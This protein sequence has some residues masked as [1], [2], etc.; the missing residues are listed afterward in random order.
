M[1]I[2][3]NGI[4]FEEDEPILKA[5]SRAFR[6]G[7]GFFESMRARNGKIL[8]QKDHEKRIAKGLSLMIMTLQEGKTPE[9]ILQDALQLMALNKLT[10]A[11]VRIQFFRD[12]GGTYLPEKSTAAY[13]IETNSLPH[14]NYVFN[15]LGLKLDIF[16]EVPK[17][18]NRLTCLKSG[19]AIAS[20]MGSIF[21]REQKLDDVLLLNEKGN[22]C[23]STN[24][25]VF[26]VFENSIKTPSLTEGA[27][28]GIMRIQTIKAA[29]E[30][31]LELL[32]TPISQTDYKKAKAAFL[33]NAVTGIRWI[34]E[35]EGTTFEKFPVEI[36]YKKILS[37][38]EEAI[39]K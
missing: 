39:A 37:F 24:S 25:N 27:V 6:F 1:K 34:Q 38:A 8:F 18:S 4:L 15:D 12:E 26:F 21:A 22:I 16:K 14:P 20:V 2:L 23:E 19:N 33:S 3:F 32:E 35:I 5:T 7:D 13:L 11:R 10:D 36:F 17:P 28:D 31:G 30:M 9:T 29:K